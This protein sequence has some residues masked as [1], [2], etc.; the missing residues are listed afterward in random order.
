MK[1]TVF[2]ILAV[3]LGTAF[4][5][6]TWTCATDSAGWSA[7]S[8]HSSVV[9]DDKVWVIGGAGG[10]DVWCS[11]DGVAWSLTTAGAQ[12]SGR[13][14]HTSVVFDNKMWVIGGSDRHDVWCSTDGITWIQATDSAG[15]AGRIYHTC[16]VFDNKMWIMGGHGH[17]GLAND[18]WYSA[19]GVDWVQ[20]T[21]SAPWTK[22]MG[23]I[24]VVFDNKMWVMG[25]LTGDMSPYPGY[26]TDVW[27][28][29][30]GMIWTQATADAGCVGRGYQTAVVADGRIWV[31]GGC[32]FYGGPSPGGISWD[33]VWYSSD[34]VDWTLATDSAG[35]SARA[36]HTSV[37]FDD[38]MWVIG[39]ADSSAQDDVW[40]STGLGVEEGPNV[41][42]RATNAATVVRSI[43]FLP[44]AVGGERSAVGVRLLDI[45]GRK[46]LDLQPGP[47]DVSRLCPGVYFVRSEPSAVSRQPSAVH[48]VVVTR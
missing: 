2:V 14:G 46:V 29:N 20:A 41:E 8:G 18:V 12:W 33:D 27:Y 22:R 5:Q 47:N 24:S 32:V 31:K 30:D 1:R 19:D 21:D 42:V 6:M 45:G 48:K 37:L 11:A 43:F 35:W 44:E 10:N 26:L 3:L 23:H 13:G 15:W 38:R 25:G 17:S 34:G 40:Y 16:V 39:G 4:A 9:F 36:G 28:S 7:R